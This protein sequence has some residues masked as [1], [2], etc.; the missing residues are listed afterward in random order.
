V[1][2]VTPAHC[3]IWYSRPSASTKEN[4][5]LTTEAAVR[6]LAA[7]PEPSRLYRWIVLLF[8]SLAMLG[9][10][11]VYDCIAPIA[12]LLGQAT[13]FQRCQYRAAAGHLQHS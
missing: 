1:T 4:S 5:T 8:I 10:Y 6:P 2:L 3:P 11:Y 13:A 7:R 9:N 12:D